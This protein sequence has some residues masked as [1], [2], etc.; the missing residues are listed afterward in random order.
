MV[1]ALLGKK[2]GMTQIYTEAGVLV[3]VT[4]IQVGPCRVTQVRTLEAD[5]YRAAQ[6]GFDPKKPKRTNK[7][8]MGHFAR[9]SSQPM[10]LIKEVAIDDG[11]EIQTGQD[12]K[13]DIFGDQKFV[14]VIGTT[15]GKGF[16]GV[17]KRWGFGGGPETHGSTSHRRPGSI[18]AG[19]DPGHILKDKGMPGHMGDRRRTV[20]NLK[21]MRVDPEQNLLLLKGAVPGAKGSYVMVR[22]SA[23]VGI[24]GKG[25]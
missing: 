25:A 16:Q 12:L 11:A 23:A 5:G 1:K 10:R 17:M 21:V 24:R 22:K 15:K 18:G 4:V 9:S 3:P 13:V 7:P 6:I 19:S 20:R 2:L 8:M 14:D